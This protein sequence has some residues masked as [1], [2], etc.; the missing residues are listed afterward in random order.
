[1]IGCRHSAV[2]IWRCGAVIPRLK[3][4]TNTEDSPNLRLNSRSSDQGV[5]GDIGCGLTWKR[6]TW[7]WMVSGRFTLQPNTSDMNTADIAETTCRCSDLQRGHDHTIHNNDGDIINFF[8]P[9][10]SMTKKNMTKGAYQL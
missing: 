4:T 7:R 10:D 9:S 3:S 6:I 5:S 8:P 1:M 2:R